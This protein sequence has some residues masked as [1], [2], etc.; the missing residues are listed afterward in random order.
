MLDETML[1]R[2]RIEVSSR[3][4]ERRYRHTLGVEAAVTV[5]GEQLC[6]E[7]TLELRAAALLHDI[8]KELPREEQTALLLELGLYTEEIP[9]AYELAHGYLAPYFIER[10]FP[11]LAS[12]DILLAVRYHTTG[13]ADMSTFEKI[14][15]LADYI[16]EGRTY[17]DC[18][19]VREFFF[20]NVGKIK[21]ERL[22]DE[23]VLLVMDKTLG[24]LM[25]HGF[26][27]ALDTVLARNSVL[28]ALS[29]Q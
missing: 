26:Y 16:E 4:S 28:R 9:L 11:E 8:A 18:A 5:L 2:V 29:H 6:P 15:F 21:K 1:D 22:L 19:L 25:K 3:M 23:A 20:S 24:Y 17:A 10:D 13:R 12:E 27:I 7:R 14:L